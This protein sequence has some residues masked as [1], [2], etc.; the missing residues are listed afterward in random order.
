[1]NIDTEI[2]YSTNQSFEPTLEGTNFLAP[3]SKSNDRPNFITTSGEEVL[4]D[5]L[6]SDSLKKQY[7]PAHKV[8]RFFALNTFLNINFKT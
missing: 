7:I 3:Q 5:L 4:Y 6:F 2:E 8:I 1:M